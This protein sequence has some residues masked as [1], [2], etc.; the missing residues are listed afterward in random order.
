[1]ACRRRAGRSRACHRR[2]RCC[3]SPIRRCRSAAAGRPWCASRLLRRTTSGALHRGARRSRRRQIHP[4]PGSR[5]AARPAPQLPVLQRLTRLLRLHRL[6]SQLLLSRPLPVLSL[7]IELLPI[8]T[9]LHEWLLSQLLRIQPRRIQPR[10]VQLRRIHSWRV[11][12]LQLPPPRPLMDLSPRRL[13]LWGL[14]RRPIRGPLG[15]SMRQ[16]SCGG[17]GISIAAAVTSTGRAS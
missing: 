16:A 9:L 5:P 12:P 2:G 13:P 17:C 6:P 10:R 1:M 14:I 7:L 3:A 8:A 4:R 15:M 11:Q